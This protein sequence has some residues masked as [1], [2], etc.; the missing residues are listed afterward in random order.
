MTW[1]RIADRNEIA[2]DECRTVKAGARLVA[3]AR[4]ASGCH[5]IDNRCL[6]VGG[7]LGQGTVEEGR[8]VCPWHGR[9]YDLATGECDNVDERI[10]VYQVEE[11]DDGIYVFIED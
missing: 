11:R 9:A 1:H 5:V 2:V 3:V 4:T 8:I 7:P 6:H 10:S